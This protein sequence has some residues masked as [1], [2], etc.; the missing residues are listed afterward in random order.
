[1]IFYYLKQDHMFTVEPL[2][3]KISVL[4]H[5]KGGVKT[6][7]AGAYNGRVV[8]IYSKYT[9]FSIHSGNKWFY[10]IDNFYDI[11]YSS[12]ISKL[13]INSRTHR[14]GILA[15]SKSLSRRFR[16]LITDNHD[17]IGRTQYNEDTFSIE[18]PSG[19][20]ISTEGVIIVLTKYEL[21]SQLATV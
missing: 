11:P 15:I 7:I 9:G 2:S 12:N 10:A 6:V 21:V 13:D 19:G 14:L 16:K 5:T 3:E 1:M 8:Y 4:Y 17:K 18:I 20:G